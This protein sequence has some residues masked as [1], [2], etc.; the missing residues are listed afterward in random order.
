MLLSKEFS[1]WV[2]VANVLAW[3]AAYFAMRSWLGGY[4]YRINLNAQLGF[5]LLAGVV[6]LAIALL[7]V[8]FQ[9]IKAA[10]AD[11]VKT[12]KYE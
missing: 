1:R 2:V 11:P 8:A 4:A 7:T 5:F 6:A 9:A 12:M 3:P 10:L